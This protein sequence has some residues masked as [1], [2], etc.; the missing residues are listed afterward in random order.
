MYDIG[1]FGYGGKRIVVVEPFLKYWIKPTP[2]D[3][4]LMNK[5]DWIYVN[6]QG[7]IK[8]P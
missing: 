1:A 6:K 2:I 5:E 8:F 7:D 3:T 4:Q